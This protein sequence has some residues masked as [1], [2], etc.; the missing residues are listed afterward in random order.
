M[1]LGNKKDSE[2]PEK[3]LS[4]NEFD[5][6]IAIYRDRILKQ[7]ENLDLRLPLADAYLQAGRADEAIQEFRGLAALYTEK[8]SIAKAIAVYKKILRVRPTMTEIEYYLLELSD[9]RT[10]AVPDENSN[11]EPASEKTDSLPFLAIDTVLFRGLSKEEFR[12]VVSHLTLRHYEEET[13][14]VSEGDPGESMFIIV[15]GE[16]RVN[17]TDASGKQFTLANLG[18]GEFFGEVSLLTG[19]PRTATII[20]NIPS[21]LLELSLKDF[22]NIVADY[23]RVREI[24]QDSQQQRAYNT[25]ESIIQSRREKQ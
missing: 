13:I 22:E 25:I 11:E 9:K 12:K 7:P 2:E 21:D 6:A 20:T 15:N 14:I 4:Q 3:L 10:A 23:P 1:V 16:V 24:L 8:G 5:R 18:E 19:K 17:T